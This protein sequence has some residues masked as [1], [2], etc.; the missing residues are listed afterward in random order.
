M[1]SK[2]NKLQQVFNNETIPDMPKA[3]NPNNRRISNRRVSFAATMKVH[4]F[5]SATRANQPSQQHPFSSSPTRSPSESNPFEALQ[6]PSTM[7]SA[8]RI[9]TTEV[10]VREDSS[11]SS[12]H[13]DE[14]ERERRESLMMEFTECVGGLIAP[15]VHDE[16]ASTIDF[17]MC[18]GGLIKSNAIDSLNPSVF[19]TN[20]DMEL[21][22]CVGGLIKDAGV[23]AIIEP[24]E[25]EDTEIVFQKA[26]IKNNQED[27]FLTMDMTACVGADLVGN[28]SVE[29]SP[30]PFLVIQSQN[31][32]MEKRF[33]NSHSLKLID[34]IGGIDDLVA[35][36]PMKV[37]QVTMDLTQVINEAIASNVMPVDPSPLPHKALL[38]EFLAESG[39]RFLDNVSSLTRRETMV[40]R[41]RESERIRPSS[42]GA[43]V[44]VTEAVAPELAFYEK[45]IH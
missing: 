43:S 33:G 20:N 36:S 3:N 2:E 26:S 11:F 34:E 1:D 22:E 30:S 9:V 16:D 10:P 15:S 29:E 37:D 32:L 14:D 41:A 13:S 27:D 31:S 39:I 45:V 21:T 28:K 40:I 8:G 25:E 7:Q 35:G 38:N 23:Q 19:D 4:E 17:T 5:A 6:V 24:E 42:T 12:F 18:V 44:Y